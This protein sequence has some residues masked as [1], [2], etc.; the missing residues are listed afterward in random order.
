[1]LRD[2]LKVLVNT[3]QYRDQ[4]SGKQEKERLQ[5]TSAGTRSVV[6]LDYR[7]T[8]SSNRSKVMRRIIR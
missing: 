8:L 2:K 5:A 1:M 4:V 3:M 6:S 7:K